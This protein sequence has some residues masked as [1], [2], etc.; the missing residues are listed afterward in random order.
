MHYV[1]IFDVK[2]D[3]EI[4]FVIKLLALLYELIVLINNTI[5]Q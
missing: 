2:P 5:L 1:R 3:V 4:F